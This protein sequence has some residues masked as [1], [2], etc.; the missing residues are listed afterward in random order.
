[1]AKK[2]TTILLVI[3][4]ILGLASC[5]KKEE[6]VIS[7]KPEERTLTVTEEE[8]LNNLENSIGM[9]E[10]AQTFFDDMFIYKSK[11]GTWCY[12]S[13]DQGLPMNDYD[14]SKLRHAGVISETEWEYYEG[15]DLVSIKGIDISEYNKVQ[16][17]YAVKSDGVKFAFIRAG[18]RGYGTGKFK[19]D[20]KF[21]DNIK[22]AYNAGINVGVY[23]VTQ[24]INTD[25]AIEEAD[26]VIDMIKQ[27]GVDVTYPIALDLE[28]AASLEARTA[29]ISKADRTLIIKAFCDRIQSYGY[30]PM[31]YSNIRWYL[32]EME[33]SELTDYCKWFAQ[34]FNKPFFPY[35]FQIWQ[36]TSSGVV[37][38]IDG[39]VDLNLCMYDFANPP[40]EQ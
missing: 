2:I 39:N 18:Y 16:D 31:L 20:T 22:G 1:L 23:F 32:D 38:G 33:L 7:A 29:D 27:A 3:V 14:W 34:Y 26:W 24:A 30:T 5:G 40:K 4:M 13:V 25:E 8:I 6:A 11:L 35:E 37:E 21:F 19:E 10:F 15:T 12:K 9:W 36:Y 17:W 28:D